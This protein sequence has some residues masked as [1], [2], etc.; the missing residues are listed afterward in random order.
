MAHPLVPEPM[1][2][3]AASPPPALDLVPPD[4]VPTPAA[5]VR[6]VLDGLPD[7]A[8]VFDPE[9]RWLY[10]NPAAEAWVRQL[11]RPPESLQGRCL[12]E[13]F[14]AL[15][16]RADYRAAREAARQGRPHAFEV[17]TE[18]SAGLRHFE[19]RVLPIPGGIVSL[20][21]DV[22]DARRRTSELQRWADL[23]THTAHGL[24]VSD[25]R[26]DTF[27]TVNPALARMLGY[28]PDE[29]HGMAVAAIYA[30]ETR[31]AMA[32][33]IRAAHA[34][35]A[36][37]FDT[38]CR[39]KDGTTLPVRVELTTLRHPDGRP[40]HRIANVQDIRELARLELRQRFLAD[41]GARLA[42]SL[43]VEATI[44]ELVRLAVPRLADWAA[45]TV[46]DAGAAALRTVEI[47]HR[48]PERLRFAHELERRYPAR[49]DDATG[50]AL[51]LRTGEPQLVADV[52]EESLAAWAR[53]AEHLMLLRGLGVRSL[54]FVPL[55]ARG[56]TL[57]VLTFARAESPERFSDDDLAFA[58]ELAQRAALAVDNARLF[59]AEQ[60]ARH[61]AERLQR[62][63][64]A[65]AGAATVGQV[66][67]VVLSQGLSALGAGA[68]SVA[69]ATPDGAA[70]ELLDTEGYEDARVEGFRRLPLDAPVPLADAMRER[71]P[72]FLADAGQALAR[73]PRLPGDDPAHRAWAAVPLLVDGRVTG[74]IALSFPAPRAFDADERSF[75]VALARQGAQAMERARLHEAERAARAEAEGA[76]RA[77]ADFLAT[78]SHELRTPINAAMGYADLMLLGIHGDVSAAQREA[79][80]RIQR[81]QRRLLALVNDVLSFARLDAGQTRLVPADVPVHELVL[82]VGVMMEPQLQARGLSYA[83]ED[84]EGPLVVRAD[85]DRVTQ[86]LLNLLAN[87]VKFTE[88]GGAVALSCAA[89][90]DVV[91]LTVRDTG[92]GIPAEKH[93][94][95]FEPFVQVEGG[96]TRSHDG[97]GLGLA[98]S[99]SL[100]R[101][102]GGE[103][104]VASAEGQGA[105]F[106]LTLPRVTAP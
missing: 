12:W 24:S 67:R 27:V 14:P 99:R 61:L 78:M 93:E 88:P 71:T 6:A 21:R 9:W 31:E 83:V 74:G 104:T 18:D 52:T 97:T 102:M 60:R 86:V 62:V 10:L 40:R 65:L 25:A 37:T 34:H 29:M 77:K 11:R 32:G 87:A 47:R 105:A 42:A 4:A 15:L 1:A 54:M 92:R 23:V 59:A 106:E 33:H 58:L 50:A 66:A 68:G 26:T 5:V 70:L 48:D 75:V 20:T 8:H 89:R 35:G 38:V 53:G 19:T 96:L 30:A 2:A 80:E 95:I 76:N 7:M 63:T 49:A 36:H 103:L 17:T 82:E 39:R 100:A 16:E 56:R 51:A 41:A 45:F 43:D 79:L 57:G 94:R 101:A 64:E 72:V 69:A 3:P 85:R 84:A 81:S 90:G 46:Q 55:V 73:Y 22:T 28:G 13:E 98:I 44:R 91:A